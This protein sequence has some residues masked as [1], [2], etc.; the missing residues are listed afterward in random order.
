MTLFIFILQIGAMILGAF[1]GRD[2]W[3]WYMVPLGLPVITV[4]HAFG[5]DLI[6]TFWTSRV[7]KEMIEADNEDDDY[8][9]KRVIYAIVKVCVF[10]F[11]GFI[12]K[13]LWM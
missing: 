10:W 8:R 11:M 13:K 4:A 7:S 12:V 3:I 1:V 5:V 9:L 6:V 2:L